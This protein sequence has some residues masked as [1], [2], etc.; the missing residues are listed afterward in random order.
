M[1]STYRLEKIN[2]S[3]QWDKFV[4]GTDYATIFQYG[5]YLDAL[6][7]RC[8]RYFVYNKQELRAAFV[9]VEDPSGEN[10]IL[11]DFLIYNGLAFGQT[12]TGQN[13]AQRLS[14]HFRITEFVAE[15]LPTI[16]KNI[17]IPL[18]PA[19]SDVRPFLWVNHGTDA[20]KFRAD[21]RYTSYL[22]ISDFYQSERLE[23][24]AAYNRAAKARRQI[25][26][27][28]KRDQVHTEEEFDAN[29]FVALYSKTMGRQ[30]I[31][32]AQQENNKMRCLLESLNEKECIRMFSSRTKNGLV[33]SMA[34]FAIDHQRAYYLFGANEPTLRDYHTGTSVLWDA[35]YILNGD[36]TNQVDLE[37]VNSPARGWFKLSFG[38]VLLPYYEMQYQG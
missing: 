25:I 19:T 37:G 28:A 35:F 36:G 33:G 17:E 20:P 4:H 10:A 15:T 32:V 34:C 30:D 1:A 3:E 26:R 7:A 6:Q 21:V 23:D 8:S 31:N 11:D 5:D 13:H 29:S 24:I 27:Y 12:T 18:T 38:G 2:N 22:D 9:I 16:Y 14:E